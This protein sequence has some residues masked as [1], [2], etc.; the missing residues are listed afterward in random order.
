[1]G[2]GVNRADAYLRG[3][4]LMVA[5]RRSR[6]LRHSGSASPAYM[7]RKSWIDYFD[8]RAPDQIL[9]V[10]ATIH[11]CYR[12]ANIYLTHVLF[13]LA[14]TGLLV[15]PVVLWANSVISARHA[16][17]TELGSVLRRPGRR[18]T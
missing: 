4:S 18:S 13:S 14:V 15:H 16:D 7:K 12:L 1:M 2:S 8:F 3:A 5:L 11:L 10:G 6:F 17:K 9:R